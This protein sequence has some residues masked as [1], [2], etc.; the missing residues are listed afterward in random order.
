ME[1][2]NFR[3]EFPLKE[4]WKARKYFR[5]PKVKVKCSYNPYDSPYG[6]L[7]YGGNILDLSI[8]GLGWKDKW[9][10]PRHEHNP[11]IWLMLFKKY[12]FYVEFYMSGFNEDCSVR[13]Y[14]MEY[15]EYMLNYLYYSHNLSIEDFWTYQSKIFKRVTEHGK[16]EDGS[17]D[18]KEGYYIPIMPQLFSLNK[19]G[20]KEFNKLYTEK[21]SK[22]YE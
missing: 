17:E 7:S 12:H 9:D 5:F 14:S 22:F 1:L 6:L 20:K 4:W 10:T 3:I 8:I 2:F 11:Y 18:V 21:M 19:R 15:W 16:S 13:D